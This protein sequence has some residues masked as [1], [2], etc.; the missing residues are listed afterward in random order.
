MYMKQV[1]TIQDNGSSM[2]SDIEKFRYI[3]SVTVSPGSCLC[4][5]SMRRNTTS[6]VS[7]QEIR[8]VM[9]PGAV[10]TESC[11]LCVASL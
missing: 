3:T 10:E 1:V 11:W 8:W 9:D 2:D 5:Q 6:V 4:T 7:L